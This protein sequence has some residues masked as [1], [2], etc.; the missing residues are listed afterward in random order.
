MAWATGTRG[1]VLRT[2]S[3]GKNWESSSVPN[4]SALDFRDI[5]APDAT[6]AWLLSSGP[7]DKSRTYRTQDSGKNWQLQLTN[8]DPTGFFDAIALFT[9]HSAILLG[10]SVDGRF[11]IYTTTDVA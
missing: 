3:S 10:D 2:N 4:S 5:E 9:K 1:T 6:H 8:P 11:V 7:G